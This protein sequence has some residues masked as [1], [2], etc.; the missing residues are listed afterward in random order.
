MPSRGRPLGSRGVPVLVLPVLT[1]RYGVVL[2]AVRQVLK[3]PVIVALPGAA[4][5]VLGLLNLRGAIVPVFDVHLLRGGATRTPAA[6]A[7]VVEVRGEPAG[8]A[9]S[10]APWVGDRGP[11]GEPDGHGR[12]WVRAGS[13]TAA[14]APLDLDALLS[15]TAAAPLAV[16]AGTGS[17]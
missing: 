9:L 7:A 1:E 10:A 14:V 6:F 12:V 16:R 17:A 2:T 5:T 4:P 3:A 15:V 8:L 13:R 11:G